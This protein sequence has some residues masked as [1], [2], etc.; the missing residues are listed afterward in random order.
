MCGLF[1]GGESRQWEHRS[2]VAVDHK[3]LLLLFEAGCL[4]TQILLVDLGRIENVNGVQSP[5]DRWRIGPLELLPTK[6]VGSCPADPG[7]ER[8]L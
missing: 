1:G 6:E 3:S 2:A 4:S 5:F 8:K 7:F